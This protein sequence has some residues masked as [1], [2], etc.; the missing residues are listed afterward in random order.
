M[1]NKFLQSEMKRVRNYS[2]IVILTNITNIII[3][4]SSNVENFKSDV[5]QV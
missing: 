4:V 1:E 2:L 3:R 5:K